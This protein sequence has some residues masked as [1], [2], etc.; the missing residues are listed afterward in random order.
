MLTDGIVEGVL[1]SAKHYG[2]RCRVASASGLEAVL[3]MDKES[4]WTRLPGRGQVVWA[5]GHTADGALVRCGLGRTAGAN[6]MDG[7]H[8]VWRS[9]QWLHAILQ[10]TNTSLLAS[11]A[12]LCHL[13]SLATTVRRWL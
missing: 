8:A 12:L 4:K 11:N 3:G 2:R 9:T 6:V 1:L 5:G 13:P 7:C 10:A